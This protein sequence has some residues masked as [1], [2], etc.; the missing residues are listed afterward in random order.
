MR[1]L[2]SLFIISFG[3]V[4]VFSQETPAD[5]LPAALD[6]QFDDF[7]G[8]TAIPTSEEDIA[9]LKNLGLVWGFLKYYHPEVAKG[10]YNWDYEL[11][12]FL[13]DY[14][15]A[16]NKNTALLQWID[17]YGPLEAEPQLLPENI[18]LLPDLDWIQNSGFP[19]QLVNK[20]EQIKNAKWEKDHYYVEFAQWINN[21]VFRNENPYFK[22]REDD[23]GFRLL[24]L[25]R[26]WNMI[27]YFF[28]YKNH[29]PEDWKAVLTEFIPQFIN[30]QKR[31]QYELTTLKLI[32]RIRDTHA[33]IWSNHDG[34]N[35]FF[36]EKYALPEVKFVEG[37]AVV[38]G[39]HTD[40]LVEAG[41]LKI[42]DIVTE[43]DGKSIQNRIQEMLPYTPASNYTTQLRDI[44]RN[45]FRSNGDQLQ[46]SVIRND[47]F[48]KVIL[49]TYPADRINKG[50]FFESKNDTSFRILP[51]NIAYIDHGLLKKS[52]IPEIW[53][54]LKQT[55]GLIIDHRNYPSDFP[56]QPLSNQLFPHEIPFVKIS[57]TGM[58]Q[59]GL[60][61]FQE[62]H[63]AGQENIDSYKGQIIILVNEV[64]QSSS[65][66]HAMV[67]R[68]HPNAKVVG[69]TT[70][71]SDGDM[72]SISLPGGIYT[73]FSGIGIF[74]PDGTATHGVGIV[75]DIE[76]K[77]SIQ[78][79]KNQIDEVLERALQLLRK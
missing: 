55:K 9:A 59:P 16:K 34:I 18:A 44:A 12:R 76:V 39:F 29:I 70:A 51:G 54:H 28:P 49:R 17:R 27:Q 72:S 26:Y 11:F 15:K 42:G 58:Q 61:V 7:S 8:I 4:S 41:E 68:A 52:T 64:T 19:K 31:D 21:A 50:K 20:L 63:S 67:Y 43:I 40:S 74:Y 22:M 65:E 13:P 2:L 78:G 25:Y 10:N 1:F 73:A 69:S 56:G 35:T 3:Y 77:P 71:A 53:P 30:A 32:G 33:N 62:P 60:F 5:S 48:K 79:I 45:L 66:Y 38:T 46:V 57:H 75:P 6:R 23:A 14:L 36:G 47:E 37:K 24:S